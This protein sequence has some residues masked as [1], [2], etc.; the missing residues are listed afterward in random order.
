MS[1]QPNSLLAAEQTPDVFLSH[2]EQIVA[3]RD[4][5]TDPELVSGVLVNLSDRTVYDVRLLVDRSWLW[6]DE[7]Y[8]ARRGRPGTRSRLHGAGCR[9]RRADSCPSP[10]G[11]GRPFPQRAD[12]RFET[13]VSV[14][15]FDQND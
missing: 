4:V 14:V 5:R 1:F 10:I 15:G 13:S 6:A 11:G 8:P 7:R 3:V 12:G 2:L 9:S